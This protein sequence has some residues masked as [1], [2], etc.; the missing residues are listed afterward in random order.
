MTIDSGSVSSTKVKQSVR[1]SQN[2]DNPDHRVYSTSKRGS[3]RTG[4]SASKPGSRFPATL[5]PTVVE[6]S[7][8]AEANE[9]ISRKPSLTSE[10]LHKH[11]EKQ[12]EQESEEDDWEPPP[13][14]A[15]ERLL[16]ARN[17]LSDED[18]D[19]QRDFAKR[20]K[21]IDNLLR[22]LAKDKVPCDI[23]VYNEVQDMLRVH[24]SRMDQQNGQVLPPVAEYLLPRKSVR[25]ALFGT[26]DRA[27]LRDD[28]LREDHPP[29]TIERPDDHDAFREALRAYT[30][31]E[32]EL[33]K[34]ENDAYSQRLQNPSLVHEDVE[35]TSQQTEDERFDIRAMKR[36]RKRAAVQIALRS[37][38][39]NHEQHFEG[40]WRHRVLRL[41]PAPLPGSSEPATTGPVEGRQGSSIDDPFEWTKKVLA[42]QKSVN[43]SNQPRTAKKPSQA[44]GIIKATCQARFTYLAT[45]LFDMFYNCPIPRIDNEDDARFFGEEFIEK[46]NGSGLLSPL[47]AKDQVR[48]I[49][50]Y[51]D[52]RGWFLDDDLTDYVNL[53]SEDIEQLEKYHAAHHTL[54]CMQLT[55]HPDY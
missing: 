5:T 53:D 31:R 25:L 46:I 30:P 9:E 37:F 47:S 35:E 45:R 27:Q 15:D 36:G 11:Q 17:F 14:T 43:E 39:T 24:Q 50:E 2:K 19:S 4:A 13:P 42:F 32:R 54:Q 44:R 22:K 7:E 23:K 28:P 40:G 3:T 6:F 26:S 12:I 38:A 55:P 51:C 49:T 18:M 8:D 16:Q 34:I 20:H 52:A 33:R 41:P 29:F 10:N 21:V 1:D 48:E